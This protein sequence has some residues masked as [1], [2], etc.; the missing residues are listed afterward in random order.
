[1]EK[2]AFKQFRHSAHEAIADPRLQLAI[3]GATGK[4]RGAR[5]EALA[6]LPNA[7]A[8][9]DHL[10]AIRSTTL[11]RLAEHLEMFERSAVQ[12]GARVHWARDAAEACR[13]V[14]EIA[15]QHGVTLAAKSK[16]MASEEIQL[17]RA[18]IDAGIEPVETDLGEWIIQLAGEPPSHII[19]PAIHKTRQQ[20]AELFSKEAGRPMPPDDIPVLTAEARRLLRGKFLAAR[21]GIS[22]VNVAVA[23]TGSIVLVTNEGNG[24]MVTSLP[25]I[26]V[27]IMGIE[28]IVPTWDDAAVWLALL[29]RSATGQPLSVYTTVITGPARP[30]DVDGP[31]EVHI[32]LLDNRRSELLGTRYE[33][34]LQCIRCGACLNICPVYRE[35]GGHAYGSPY[36]G[37]IGAVISPLL[38]GLKEYEALP[39]ASSLCGAC[40]DVCPVRID[41]PG[42]LLALRADEVQQRIIRGPERLIETAAAY[43]LGHVRLMNFLTAVARLLQLPWRRGDHLHLPVAAAGERR[44]PALAPRS[45]RQIWESG[46]IES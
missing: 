8:L 25:P 31:Q 37:P 12:A 16:S 35:V 42:M 11:A 19:A 2:A 24:R 32:V 4:F 1:M 17:N 10:K 26:H 39:H 44:L 38:F 43:V 7:D 40:L 33:E 28:K 22:G 41:L 36:S 21:M 14:V 46:E 30:E 20:V 6:E 18:L 27:A 15:R 9:R 13:I 29:A 23:E 45:F 5:L 3:E 34:V